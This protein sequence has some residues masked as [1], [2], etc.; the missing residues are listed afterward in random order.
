MRAIAIEIGIIAEDRSDVETLDVL[1][2][3]LVR[4]NQYK[5]RN[6]VGRGG[7][8]LKKKC[9]AWAKDLCRKGCTALIVA[10][11]LDDACEEELRRELQSSF[12]AEDFEESLVLIPIREIEAWLLADRHALKDVLSTK[13]LP[14][15]PR[16]PETIVDPKKEIRKVVKA[17]GGN[18]YINTVHNSLIAANAKVEEIYKRCKSFR[19]YHDFIQRVV[20]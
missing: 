10:H 7:G 14:K 17:V 8:R 5:V 15:V 2:S 16:N 3:R 18:S 20:L 1:A 11:D 6:F 12:V 13:T 9:G 19:P 4:H